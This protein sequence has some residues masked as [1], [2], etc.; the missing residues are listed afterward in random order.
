MERLFFDPSEEVGSCDVSRYRV[1]KDRVVLAPESCIALMVQSA[2][3]VVCRMLVLPAVPPT[4]SHNRSGVVGNM[5]VPLGVG[6]N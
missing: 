1:I 4:C 5:L 6:R 2:R 3:S